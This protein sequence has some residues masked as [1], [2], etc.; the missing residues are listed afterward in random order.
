MDFSVLLTGKW[1]KSEADGGR[2]YHYVLYKLS[3]EQITAHLLDCGNRFNP[4]LIT[5]VLRM[6]HAE[7]KSILRHIMIARIFTIHQLVQ[8]LKT[9]SEEQIRYLIVA[10]IDRLIRDSSV[11]DYEMQ[12][13]MK[14]A[15]SLLNDIAYPVCISVNKAICLNTIA[16]EITT[17]EEQY[18]LQ[19]N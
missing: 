5:K 15:A 7:I 9:I 11:P 19:H 12:N 6:E 3:R 8:K 4:H 10:D 2:F 13:T 18:Y 14:A 17:W 1:T 16:K